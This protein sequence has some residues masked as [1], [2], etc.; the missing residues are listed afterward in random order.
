MDEN[1]LDKLKYAGIVL[2]LCGVTGLKSLVKQENKTLE[3]KT[4]KEI[5]VD[6]MKVDTTNYQNSINYFNYN[7][8]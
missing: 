6:S 2:I 8:K 4:Q 7:K 1:K 5:V 3:Q